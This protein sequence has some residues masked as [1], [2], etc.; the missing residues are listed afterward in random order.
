MVSSQVITIP[1][2]AQFNIIAYKAE[3]LHKTKKLTLNI[4]LQ[5]NFIK[6]GGSK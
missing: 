3:E 6:T 4:G 1:L 5:L 2:H